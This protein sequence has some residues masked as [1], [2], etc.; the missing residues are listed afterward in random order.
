MA[1]RSSWGAWSARGMGRR[2]DWTG[3]EGE[4]DAGCVLVLG[5]QPLP[6]AR[7]QSLWCATNFSGGISLL[8]NQSAIGIDVWR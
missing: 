1:C 2:G 6:D 4:G 3:R 7:G 5:P 8:T